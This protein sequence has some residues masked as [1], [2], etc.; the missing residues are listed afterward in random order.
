MLHGLPYQKRSHQS[1]ANTSNSTNQDSYSASSS[2]NVVIDESVVSIDPQGA[3]N[4][5]ALHN[6]SN[7]KQVLLSTVMVFIEDKDGIKQPCRAIL[8]NGSQINI[9]KKSLVKRLRMKSVRSRLPISGVNGASTTSS[10]EAEIT[11]FSRQHQFYATIGC[12]V[13]HAIT[14][15]VP[16]QSVDVSSWSIPQHILPQLADPE[17]FLPSE[18]ELLLGT[19][20]F[21]EV[22]QGEKLSLGKE[23]PWLYNTS[24]G[25]IVSGSI[26]STTCR[27]KINPHAS[28]CLLNISGW[29]KS[30]SITR[31]NVDEASEL[32]FRETYERDSMGRFSV[33]LP[34]T[35][36][37]RELGSSFQMAF[38]RFLN[39]EKKFSVAPQLKKEYLSFMNEYAALGHMSKINDPVSDMTMFYLPH[40]AV[41]K[42][43]SQTTKVRV[44]FD[45][46][47]KTTSGKSLNDILAQGPAIQSELF[48]L[49]LRFRCHKIVITADVEKMFRQVR[50]H[51]EDCDF[52]RV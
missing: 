51:Q 18:V 20:I 37:P 2:S 29:M 40:H 19:D 6:R 39:L 49:V 43:T 5:A 16:G 10:E 28:S 23:L 13:L 42:E 38:K 47:A 14:N 8:D 34:F 17:F 36:D 15:I 25:W 12:H 52:Q 50:V 41:I 11:I 24:F 9:I 30:E 27:V 32:M 44:V 33:R 21:F 48:D 22:L 45:A 1:D 35:E 7:A 31:R 3:V 4:L 46:S 26:G